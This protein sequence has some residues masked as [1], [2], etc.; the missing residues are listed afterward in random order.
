MIYTFIGV[1]A[2]LWCYFN[3]ELEWKAKPKFGEEDIQIIVKKIFVFSA[4]MIFTFYQG[5]K[6]LNKQFSGEEID[7]SITVTNITIIPG[8]IALDRVLNQIKS[9][10][11]KISESKRTGRGRPNKTE[12]GNFTKKGGNENELNG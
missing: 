6:Q 10:K 7:L 2:I 9:F 12:E 4:I 5:Y 11:N 1:S 8:I 3:W